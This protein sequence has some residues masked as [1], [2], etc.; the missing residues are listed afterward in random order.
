MRKPMIRG[1]MGGQKAD[2]ANQTKP[3]S[4]QSPQQQQQ[5]HLAVA[6]K[7]VCLLNQNYCDPLLYSYLLYLKNVIE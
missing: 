4:V 1:Q 7:W 2:A 5:Q 3:Q 6:N